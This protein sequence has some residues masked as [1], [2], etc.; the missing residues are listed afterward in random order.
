MPNPGNNMAN[1]NIL[2]KFMLSLSD[3][4]CKYLQRIRSEL[5]I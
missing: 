5:P 2:N 4:K 1:P 3:P